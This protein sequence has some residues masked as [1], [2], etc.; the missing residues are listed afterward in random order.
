MKLQK[1]EDAI[2]SLNKA[3]EIDSGMVSAVFNLSVAYHSLGQTDKAVQQLESFLSRAD[4]EKD[5]ARIIAAQGL[6]QQ[7]KEAQ[8]AAEEK[9]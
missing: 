2:Q 7:F 4:M 9:K 6:M 5:E 1:P 8:K 3:L